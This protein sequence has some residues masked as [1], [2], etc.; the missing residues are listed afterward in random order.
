MSPA[1]FPFDRGEQMAEPRYWFARR[2]P[3]GHPRRS[4]APIN[5]Q[6]FAVV[7]Q[8]V[9]FMSGGAV[10]A[11]A[12]SLLGFWFSMPALYVLAGVAFVA[13]AAYGGWR[14]IS[15]AQSRGDHAHTVEDYREG[16]VK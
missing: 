12:L 4:M 15:A 2:F 7:R 14:L 3:V 10:I 1:A 6:G 13:G 8:F 5:A 9:S 11:V 16:R